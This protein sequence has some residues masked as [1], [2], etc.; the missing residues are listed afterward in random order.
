MQKNC[1]VVT[2]ISTRRDDGASEVPRFLPQP[3][4]DPES[5]FC[6]EIRAGTVK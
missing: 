4:Q 5:E 2:L 6:I 1:E 3:E